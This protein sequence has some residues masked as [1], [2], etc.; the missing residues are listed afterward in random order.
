[1][2][3]ATLALAAELNPGGLI[4]W[5]VIGLVAGFLAGKV[6]RGSGY[7]VVGDLVMGL[8]GAFVGGLL[9]NLLVPDAN[10]GFWGS[11]IIAFLGACLLVYVVRAVSHRRAL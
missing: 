7:G 4:A 11:L 8:I 5:L 2:A 10:F 6:M 3:L 9:T 1:M